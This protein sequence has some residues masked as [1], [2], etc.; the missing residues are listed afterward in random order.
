MIWLWPKRFQQII[1]PVFSVFSLIFYPI[2]PYNR[3]VSM[4]HIRHL[5]DCTNLSQIGLAAREIFHSF[6]L[7]SDDIIMA[8]TKI[9]FF[10]IS[11]IAIRR[12]N[13]IWTP[14]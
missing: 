2:T 1:T 7:Q 12:I 14:V 11:T 4:I 10:M 3:A 6:F 8:E 5:V 9:V 13:A